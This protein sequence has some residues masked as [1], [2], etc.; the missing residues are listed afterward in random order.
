MDKIDGGAWFEQTSQN[1]LR[2]LIRQNINHPSIFVWSLFNELR[3]GNPDPH[4]ELQL[5]NLI[6][7]SEDPT[8][9]TIAATCTLPLPNMNKIADLLGWNVYYGWYA[10]WGPLSE[11]DSMCATYQ[12]TSRHRGFCVSEYGAGANVDQH[13]ENPAKPKNAGQWHPEEYQAILHEKAWTE[14]KT[15]PCIWG[16]FVWCMFDF[17]SY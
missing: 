4:R 1:Q 16:T 6:A 13:E 12:A 2:D 3:S 5:L 14:L 9:P 7:H 8:R 10:D 15:A 17:T 11:F